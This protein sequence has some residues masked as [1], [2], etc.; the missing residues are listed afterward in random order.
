[1]RGTCLSE[2][3]YRQLSAQK[4]DSRHTEK[5][6]SERQGDNLSGLR[7][8]RLQGVNSISG[9]RRREGDSWSGQ[10]GAAA[11]AP[12]ARSP[13]WTCS[14]SSTRGGSSIFRQRG[15]GLRRRSR[16]TGYWTPWPGGSRGPPSPH[17]LHNLEYLA[18]ALGHY[19]YDFMQP[20]CD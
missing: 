14:A 9:L 10:T 18:C 11:P 6:L 15:R 1:M 17:L 12:A 13:A 16:G 4:E 2:R 20:R 5:Q 7:E 3:K 19:I 8:G